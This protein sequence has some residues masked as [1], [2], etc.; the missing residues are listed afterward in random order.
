MPPTMF[1]ILTHP[2]ENPSDLTASPEVLLIPIPHDS[3]ETENFTIELI[4]NE[5]HEYLFTNFQV[6]EFD[7][8]ALIKLR[9]LSQRID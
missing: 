7:Q 1:T 6:K 4:G 8:V 5:N 2:T 9:D 3:V